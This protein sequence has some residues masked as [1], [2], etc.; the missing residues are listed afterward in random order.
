MASGVITLN[1]SL[2]GPGPSWVEGRL[3]DF[4]FRRLPRYV[5]P[6]EW[7]HG[8]YAQIKGAVAM[9]S[10]AFDRFS[11]KVLAMSGTNLTGWQMPG[12]E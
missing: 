10:A 5:A 9:D 4:K 12:H 11:F 7:G 2:V 8:P 6:L 1:V 3:K